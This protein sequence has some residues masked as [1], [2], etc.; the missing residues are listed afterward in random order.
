MDIIPSVIAA[1]KEIKWFPVTSVAS[2]QFFHVINELPGEGGGDR[3][4][5]IFTMYFATDEDEI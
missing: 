1:Q 3:N 2:V 5:K 4:Q